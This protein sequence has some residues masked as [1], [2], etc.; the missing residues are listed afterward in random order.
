M[1]IYFLEAGGAVQIAKLAVC[2]PAHILIFKASGHNALAV[3][4]LA[5]RCATDVLVRAHGAQAALE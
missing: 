3:A 4:R 1:A 2:L 5:S